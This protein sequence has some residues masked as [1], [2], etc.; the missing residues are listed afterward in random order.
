MFTASFASPAG[1]VT[2]LTGVDLAV[3]GGEVVAIL[4]P[5]GSGKS[6]L[7]HLLA[8][9]DKPTRGEVWW[10]EVPVHA[11]DNHVLARLRLVKVGLVFQNHYLLEDLS[12][13]ENVTLSGRL[14]GKVDTARGENLLHAVGLVARRDFLPAKLSGGER[15]RV[16]VARALY[17]KPN[18]VLAD[19]PTGSLD[20]HSA[21]GVFELLVALARDEG[22]AVVMVTHDEGLVR[23]VD[24][25]YYLNEGRLEV[26]ERPA[27]H[28]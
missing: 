8:G 7:L 15:Q 5:S 18:I 16:A 26:G 17:A 21:G 24:R 4:G 6:T 25:R 23:N 2:V 10:G 3:G 27:A 28:R 22:S 19:E 14:A 20:R 1:P 12:V 13:L 11:T 9:L